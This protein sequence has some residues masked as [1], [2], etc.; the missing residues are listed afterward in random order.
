MPA[1]H[2]RRTLPAAMALQQQVDHQGGENARL[3]LAHSTSRRLIRRPNNL[4]NATRFDVGTGLSG[5]GSVAARHSGCLLLLVGQRL[6]P[7]S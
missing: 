4:G 5:R 6:V 7:V 1:M 2:K 3:S